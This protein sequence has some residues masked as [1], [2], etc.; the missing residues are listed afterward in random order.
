MQTV[1]Y[2]YNRNHKDFGRGIFKGQNWR[3][4]WQCAMGKKIFLFGAGRAC[5]EF[6][7]EYGD[8]MSIE[9]IF[10]N[11]RSKCGD[12]MQG[13][14]IIP[15]EEIKQYDAQEFVILI[16]S[17][18]FDDEIGQQLK[19]AG[20]LYFFSIYAIVSK[21]QFGWKKRTYDKLFNYYFGIF[22]F[23][24]KFYNYVVFHIL[25]VLRILRFP[26]AYLP[27]KG[28]RKY[29]NI[30]KNK[31][32]FIIANGPSLC[33]EDLELLHKN[34]EITFG[35]NSIFNIF[36]RTDWRPDYYVI[37]DPKFNMLFDWNDE[38]YN[39]DK[40]CKDT[41][42]L[43]EIYRKTCKK[44]HK[45]QFYPISFLGHL[46]K[47]YNDTR[48]IF[49]KNFV[50]G[51]YC[52]FTVT[53]VCIQLAQWMGFSEVYLLG[54][55]CNYSGPQK[56]FAPEKDEYIYTEEYARQVHANLIRGYSF[57]GEHVKKYGTTVYN[58]TRGGSLEVF[59]RV[60]LEKLF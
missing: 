37:E 35:M 20:V 32:C 27:Y 51:I 47:K 46:R 19:N 13:I 56:H 23:T 5:K 53:N 33:V 21:E 8:R 58:A 31:R 49:S 22:S 52:A 50:W 41:A 12:K 10:E 1:L 43:I 29:K 40:V 28:V 36:D 26:P 2:R 59:E 45:V 24:G 7:T 57:I 11:D 25:A 6:L 17:T 18:Q 44:F 42:F 55:D 39:L 4:F 38:K 60:D 3:K 48:M 15:S 30:H 34:N 54:A 9:A 16:S 14:R